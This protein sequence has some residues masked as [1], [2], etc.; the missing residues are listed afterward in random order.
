MSAKVQIDFVANESDL[1]AAANN[2]QREMDVLSAKLKAAGVSQAAYNKAVASQ[3]QAAMS[4]KAA[5]DA[6]FASMQKQMASFASIQKQKAAALAAEEKQRAAA[7]SAADAAHQRSTVSFTEMKSAIDLAAMALQKLKQGYDFAKEGAQ[8]EFN[9]MKFDRLAQTIGTTGDVLLSRFRVATKG[10]MSD[11]EAMAMATDL[12]ALGMVKT[13]KDAVRLATVVS[14]LGMDMNQLTLALAGQTTMRFDQLGIAVIGFDEKVKKLKETGLDANEAFTQAFLQQAEDQLKKVGNAGDEA[15]GDFQRFEAQVKNLKSSLQMLAADALGPLMP[16]LTNLVTTISDVNRAYEIAKEKGDRILNLIELSTSGYIEQ[17]RAEREVI[18]TT[19]A[20]TVAKGAAIP[21]TEELAAAEKAVADAAKAASEAN[22][23]FLGV[24]GQVGT[25]QTAYY[26]G[27]REANLALAEGKIKTEEHSAKVN[28]LA[29]DYQTAKTQIVLSIVEMKLAADGWTNAELNAYLQV[30]Q[31][32]GQFTADQVSMAKGAVANADKIVAGFTGTTTAA[33]K[34]SDSIAATGAAVIETTGP[35]NEMDDQVL[36]LGERAEDA[37]VGLGEMGTGAE[38][39]GA[40]IS[41]SA[42]P[43]VA[44]LKSAINQLQDKVVN[45][46]VY[47]RQHGSLPKVGGGW[48]GGEHPGGGGQQ[49]GGEVY[50][51]QP[52]L[53]GEAGPEPFLPAVNGRILSHAESLHQLSLAGGM[54]QRNV[55][56]GPVSLTI[57]EEGVGGIMGLR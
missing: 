11:M 9:A 26:T 15:L 28:Q 42:I 40:S 36:H 47:I 21:T 10:T 41:T 57:G 53:V 2:A 16:A 51:G 45:I 30:G 34:M 7:A 44:G 49:M 4:A 37:A 38:E 55:F 14:G 39:L 32:M 54:G 17:A 22:Q 27:L 31:E 20:N 1:L 50:A 12:V 5:E 46:D 18:I 24:L 56:Y 43:A 3:K 6:R 13:E 52:T 19:E 33:T 35:V 8:I 29:L 23:L 25:A 48:G